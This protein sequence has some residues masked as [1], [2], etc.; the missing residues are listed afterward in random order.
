MSTDSEKGRSERGT[1][2]R[3]MYD[4]KPQ[5]RFAPVTGSVTAPPPPPC[6]IAEESVSHPASLAKSLFQTH[7]KA[8]SA[9]SSTG[10]LTTESPLRSHSPSPNPGLSPTA[11]LV[12]EPI[13]SPSVLDAELD[14]PPEAAQKH[15][16][17]IP[18]PNLPTLDIPLLPDSSSTG[19]TP[20]PRGKRS[21]ISRDPNL[22]SGSPTSL[23]SSL[24][25]PPFLEVTLHSP[26]SSPTGDGVGS[27]ISMYLSHD[28]PTSVEL[29]PFPA[30]AV[31][32]DSAIGVPLSSLPLKAA[33]SI[34]AVGG[35]RKGRA[36]PPPPIPP[37]PK[38]PSASLKSFDESTDASHYSDSDP[39][40]PPVL[41]P[42]PPT[43]PLRLSRMK[44][45]DAQSRASRSS[46]RP[47]F[48]AL[49]MPPGRRVLR[50]PSVQSSASTPAS[51]HSHE[52]SSSSS[53]PGYL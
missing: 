45:M 4:W 40:T 34:G 26:L 47:A 49:P 32:R 16:Q 3:P 13:A 53:H 44:S 23:A 48:R 41:P 33:V 17:T 27:L 30:A 37:H 20:S 46:E 52:K 6:S 36:P 2:S 21:R 24:S 39:G 19:L 51:S 15:T 35:G 43:Q 1:I 50:N 31:Q 8:G 11:V 42:L 28:S 5:S 38:L 25:T 7:K 12:Q 29:P 10:L 9:N 18:Q 22:I 14:V